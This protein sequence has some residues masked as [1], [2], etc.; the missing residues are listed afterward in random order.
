MQAILIT[1]H[2]CMATPAKR[3]RSAPVPRATADE[4]AKQ[5][6]EDMYA[7][8]GVL[9]CKFCEHCIHYVWVDTI[10]DHLQSQKHASRLSFLL[11]V[12]VVDRLLSLL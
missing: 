9:F 5:F 11:M 7:D 12:V 6:Q 3:A 2:A 10:K 4:R 8:G 1:R